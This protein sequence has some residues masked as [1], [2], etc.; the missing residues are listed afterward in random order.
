MVL[1]STWGRPI[2]GCY[3]NG[4]YYQMTTR[5]LPQEAERKRQQQKEEAEL[6][7]A[8]AASKREAEVGQ[9]ASPHWVAGRLF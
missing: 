2:G 9:D 1:V 4:A 6:E 3:D 7:R 5:S 8:I